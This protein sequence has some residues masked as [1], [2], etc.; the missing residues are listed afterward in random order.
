MPNFCRRPP[1]SARIVTWPRLLRPPDFFWGSS[2]DFSGVPRV[3][4]SKP[5]TERNRVP[6]VIG[7]HCRMLISALEDGEGLA[8]LQSDDRLLPAASGPADPPAGHLRAPHLHR[9]HRSDVDAELLLQRLA[10]LVLVR[11]RMHLEG[12][13]LPGLVRRGALL[14]DERADH[15]VAKRGHQSFSFFFFAAGFL[16]GAFLAAGF[17]SA[18]GRVAAF[19]AVRAASFFAV[20]AAGFL[21][22]AGLRAFAATGS[23]AA[24]PMTT[25]A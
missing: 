20:R 10:D 2:S 13:L 4:S 9:A 1:P 22:A 15:R 25:G 18:L 24:A 12:V 14:G 21:T 3:I 19:F 7:R 23:P 11:L 5:D 17:F 6:A 16:A 8:L